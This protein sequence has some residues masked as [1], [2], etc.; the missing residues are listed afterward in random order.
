MRKSNKVYLD[1]IR[2]ELQE[3]MN[4]KDPIYAFDVLYTGWRQKGLRAETHS[5][6]YY[7]DVRRRGWL[8]KKD[9]IDLCLYCHGGLEWNVLR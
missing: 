8:T 1:D 3:H 4:Y 6:Q 2:A 7:T 5:K 9:A